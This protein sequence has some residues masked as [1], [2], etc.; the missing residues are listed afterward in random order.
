MK[1]GDKFVMVVPKVEAS[2]V[3]PHSSQLN[4]E[5][6]PASTSLPT[7]NNRTNEEAIQPGMVRF[8]KADIDEAFGY[9]SLLVG[10]KVDPSAPIQRHSGVPIIFCT[11]T[12]LTREEVLYALEALLSWQGY[13]PV[14]SEDGFMRL[15]RL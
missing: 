7:S 8:S 15:K 5:K 3:H 10:G 14:Q 11:Q 9:Y 12:S 1:D 2:R 4:S 6:P 13:Q